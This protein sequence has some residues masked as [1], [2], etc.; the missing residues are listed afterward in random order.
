[1]TDVVIIRP[2]PGELAALP[3]IDPEQVAWIKRACE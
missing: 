1:M 3:I 2:A